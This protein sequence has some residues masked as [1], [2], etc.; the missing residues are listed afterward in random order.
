[1]TE[2]ASELRSSSE[3]EKELGFFTALLE[4]EQ[5][6]DECLGQTIERKMVP[7]VICVVDNKFRCLNFLRSLNRLL[8]R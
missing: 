6:F 7:V 5:S 3:V 4:W 2:S 8:L 1:M